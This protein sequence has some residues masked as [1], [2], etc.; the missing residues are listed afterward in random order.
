[1]KLKVTSKKEGF[2]RAGR[3][4][5]EAPTIVE[6]SEFTKEQLKALRND[7]MLV[8]DE[9][10]DRVAVEVKKEALAEAK[11]ADA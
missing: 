9:V 6:S 7:S 2:H 10:T 5:S 3:A 8:V 1:M 11:K 4:W